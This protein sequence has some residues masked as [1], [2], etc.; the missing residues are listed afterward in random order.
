MMQF[1]ARFFMSMLSGKPV[2]I[3]DI[4]FSVSHNG[5][6]GVIYYDKFYILPEVN[7]P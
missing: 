4:F 3:I 6:S 1:F 5:D 7:I 2:A